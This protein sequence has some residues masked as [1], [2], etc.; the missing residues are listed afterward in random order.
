M[1][2]IEIYFAEIKINMEY[3]LKTELRFIT[4]IMTCDNYAL[5]YSCN[6]GMKISSLMR[7]T[8]ILENKKTNK[9][10][11]KARRVVLEN[12]A[13]RKACMLSEIEKWKFESKEK[14]ELIDL[15]LLTWDAGF[16]IN[17]IRKIRKL[18]INKTELRI[19]HKLIYDFK[20]RLVSDDFSLQEACYEF[21]G[22]LPIWVYNER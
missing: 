15:F 14:K 20:K 19:A 21:Y 13:T 11:K 1:A 22:N 16:D 7:K 9:L 5:M 10:W 3:T 6:I 12:D 18:L 17:E 2:D 4:L 8:S